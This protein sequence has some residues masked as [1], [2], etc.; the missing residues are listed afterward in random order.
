MDI[1]LGGARDGEQNINLGRNELT[2][3]MS[4]LSTASLGFILEVALLVPHRGSSSRSH[5]G[6]ILVEFVRHSYVA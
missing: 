6:S 3:E 4:D 2:L 5:D 1:V